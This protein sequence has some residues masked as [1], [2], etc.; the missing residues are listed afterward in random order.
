MASASL[1]PSACKQ[2]QQP[3]KK[4]W[5]GIRAA[6]TGRRRSHWTGRFM[7]TTK[8]SS[9]RLGSHIILFQKRKEKTAQIIPE[10]VF[11]GH[12]AVCPSRGLSWHAGVRGGV[13]NMELNANGRLYKHLKKTGRNQR[14]I[15]TQGNA[16]CIAHSRYPQCITLCTIRKRTYCA[17]HLA[18][19]IRLHTATQ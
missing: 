12:W 14:Y 5:E 3:T 2:K 19:E 6:Q 16:Q 15:Y 8:Q 7:F 4:R 18:T 17:A 10:S 9:R 11:S 1:T 13:D